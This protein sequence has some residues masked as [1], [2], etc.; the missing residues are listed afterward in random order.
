MSL[1][2]AIL[3]LLSEK[4]M[5]GYDLKKIMQD[6]EYMYWSGNNNQIYKALLQLSNDNFLI[7]ETRHQDGAPTKKIYRITDKGRTALQEWVCSTQPEVPEF[8]KPFLIQMVCFAQ[9]ESEQIEKIV[10]EYQHKLNT[11]LIMQKKKQQQ[12]P[13]TPDCTRQK[14]FIEDMILDN[15]LSFYQ[16]ELE[17]TQKVLKGICKNFKGE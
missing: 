14:R 5:S 2:Y 11:H 6:S 16:S 10:L 15:V 13:S 12:M 17:W 3:G 1:N 7:S 4:P 9:L 8:K